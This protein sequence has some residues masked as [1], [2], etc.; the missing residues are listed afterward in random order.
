MLPS[1]SPEWR[2]LGRQHFKVTWDWDMSILTSWLELMPQKAASLS[3][4][5]QT[6][7]TG[8]CPLQETFGKKLIVLIF[9]KL[10]TLWIPKSHCIRSLWREGCRIQGWE[11]GIQL[12]TL[13]LVWTPLHLL[14][15]RNIDLT[16]IN[17][18]LVVLKTI[19]MKDRF[20]HSVFK[21]KIFISQ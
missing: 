12:E 2:H 9:W 4:G 8:G 5:T 20:I 21:D 17:N 14:A 10:Y 15:E 7:Y 3:I 11:G 16:V 13:E 6:L 18:K 1:K 19:Y